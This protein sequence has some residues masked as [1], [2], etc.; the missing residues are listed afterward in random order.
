MPSCNIK[1]FKTKGCFYVYDV[2]SNKIVKVS[3]DTYDIIESEVC[4]NGHRATASIVKSNSNEELVVAKE[5]IRSAKKEL[6]C[7]S[8]KGEIFV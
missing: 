1:K 2:Y 8:H 5:N 7:I 6:A 3:K 4:E